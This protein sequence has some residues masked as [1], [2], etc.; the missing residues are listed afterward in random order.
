MGEVELEVRPLGRVR[1]AV[2]GAR[3]LDVLADQRPQRVVRLGPR[4]D[5][6]LYGEM[7][8][9]SRGKKVVSRMFAASTSRLIQRSSPI[10]NPPC[11]GIPYLNVWR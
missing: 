7:R 11:G 5:D 9:M 8:V 1:L 6:E 2:G 3:D 4:G 10:A